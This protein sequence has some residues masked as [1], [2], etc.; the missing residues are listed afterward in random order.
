MSNLI[1]HGSSLFDDLFHDLS[2]GFSV[3]PLHGDA[4]PQASQIKI[5]VQEADDSFTVTAEL[6]GVDKENIDVSIDNA[7]VTI[8]AEINQHDQEEKQ[9]KLLRSERY[10]GSVSRRFQLP[11]EVDA[12]KCQANYK[13]GILTLNLTKHQGNASK[14][15]TIN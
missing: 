15:L 7:V 10:F 2:S 14:K 13:N 12:D 3:R 8:S 5:D 6:P 11:A 4:L 9:G 1:R